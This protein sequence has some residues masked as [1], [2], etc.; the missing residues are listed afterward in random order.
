MLAG[1]P[2]GAQR[3]GLQH[4]G[5]VHRRVQNV[6]EALH[7]PVAHH[8][9]AIDAQFRLACPRPVRLHDLKQVGGLEAHRLQRRTG[10]LVR[11]RVYG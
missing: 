11:P 7:G 9:A 1:E 5:P 3:R 10:E 4:H 6:S 2:S 8:H